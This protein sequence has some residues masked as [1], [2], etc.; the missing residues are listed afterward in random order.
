MSQANDSIRISTPAGAHLSQI[1]IRK[2]RISKDE[3]DRQSHSIR[4]A[5]ETTDREN[6]APEQ[7][8]KQYGDNSDN[9]DKQVNSGGILDLLG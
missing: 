9:S 5:L 2:R 6:V 1:T 8:Q 7:Q 3:I 4:D